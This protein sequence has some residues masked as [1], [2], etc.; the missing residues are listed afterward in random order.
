MT[1]PAKSVLCIDDDPRSLELR[2]LQLEQAG[3]AVVTSTSPAKGLSLFLAGRFDVV[4][5]DYEMG[6]LNGGEL[7]RVIKG[8][9]PSVPVMILSAL[10]WLPDDAP[11]CID[12]FVSK[13]EPASWM[14][15]KIEQMCLSGK[16][17]HRLPPRKPVC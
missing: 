10:P 8:L 5:L 3:F 2:R 9:N 16:G 4:V 13:C 12:A 14:T 11:D 15:Y 6:D 7:A 1:Q 17:G